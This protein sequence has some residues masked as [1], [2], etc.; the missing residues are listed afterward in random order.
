M[1]SRDVV[2]RVGATDSSTNEGGVRLRVRRLLDGISDVVSSNLTVVDA[3]QH[4]T[5]SDGQHQQLATTP[6]R[7]RRGISAVLRWIIKIVGGDT[8][9]LGRVINSIV[10]ATREVLL[11]SLGATNVI[12]TGVPS[13]GALEG[14]HFGTR[15]VLLQ[16]TSPIT[17]ADFSSILNGHGTGDSNTDTVRRDRRQIDQVLQFW[18]GQSSPDGNQKTL[19]MIASSS[20]ELLDKV[21]A[22]I[23]EKFR[24]LI[25][26]LFSGYT[27]DTVGADTDS[28]DKTKVQRWVDDVELYGWQGKMAAIIAL[29]QLSRHIH[30]HDRKKQYETQERSG[31]ETTVSIPEQQQLDK[32]A[33]RVSSKLQSQHSKELSTGMIPLP[34][35]IFGIMPLRHASTIQDVAVVQNNVEAAA[36]L[37]EEMDRM[38]RRFRKATNR[39]M[40]ALQDEARREGKLGLL[41]TD[42]ESDNN[43]NEFDDEQ[44]LEVFPFEADM[45]LAQDHPVTKTIRTF[46]SKNGVAHFSDAWFSRSRTTASSCNKKDQTTAAAASSDHI[47]TT[48]VSLSGGVDSMVIA[49]ALAYLRDT[50]A[51]RCNLK[52]D[53]VLRIICI[54]I[55]YANRPESGA[56]AAYVGRYCHQIGAQFVC[57]KIDEVT[58]GVNARDDYERIAREIRFGLYRQY[59]G[60]ARRIGGQESDIGIGVML[61]HHR[62]MYF[63]RCSRLILSSLI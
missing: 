36:F 50:E 55:D 34:M 57:R 13:R 24:G 5:A 46:L 54:H 28:L 32:L 39:R 25:W 37:H 42:K 31:D 33:Y 58:R 40:A 6:P 21:D 60:E 48:I 29:D 17:I 38:I 20:E 26:D 9:R 14:G 56:E 45:S 8:S 51:A 41:A 35:Q 23:S 4:D 3:R 61:G 11:R 43:T 1:S 22:D 18:F 62:G 30:R 15:Q 49:S 63:C 52:P 2:D 10:G 7:R 53:K 19:W 44:I 59:C 27:S 16:D 12:L 47:P